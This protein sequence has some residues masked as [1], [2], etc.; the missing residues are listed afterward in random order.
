MIFAIKLLDNDSFAVFYDLFGI[1]LVLTCLIVSIGYKIRILYKNRFVENKKNFFIYICIHFFHFQIDLSKFIVLKFL[2]SI[3]I[4]MRKRFIPVILFIISFTFPQFSK[5]IPAYPFP[6]KVIQPDGTEI[7]IKL[8][9][10]E[11]FHYQT[12]LDGYLITR[13]KD[14]FFKY[15]K[16]SKKKKIEPSKYRVNNIEKRTKEEIN[17]VKQLPK[18]I[19]FSEQNHLHRL[20]RA[21][22]VAV[23]A[24]SQSRAYPLTGSPKSLVI[25]VNFSDNS[26][27]INSPKEAFTKL[28]NQNG[29]SENGST[30]SARDY[31]YDTSTGKFNPEFDVVGPYTLPQTI[32]YYGENDNDD[33]DKN[34]QQMIIDACRLA[35]NDGVDFSQYDTDK[36]GYVDN[37]F[38]YY[39][40]YNEAEGA[41]ANTI[42]PHRWTLANYNTK[43]DGVVVFDYACSSELRSSR[44]SNMCG[45]GTFCHEFGHVLGLP[46]YYP[47]DGG[48][49]FTLSY[50]NIMDAGAYL[51][52]GKTPPTYSAFDRFFLNWLAPTELKSSE[53]FTLQPLTS[54]NNAYLIS[55]DGNHNLKGNAP[56]PTE[57]FMLENRQNSG[58]DT[59]LPGHG[60]LVTHI[61]YNQSDWENN[62][63]N[64]VAGKLDYE[65]I[66]AD[67]IGSESTLSGD[68][69]PGKENVTT[70]SLVLRD[71][72]KLIKSL[73]NITENNNNVNF[74]FVGEGKYPIITWFSNF[75]TFETVQG[76]PS[77]FQILKISGKKLKD[78]IQI[79]FTENKY[80]EMRL[81]NDFSA[82]WTKNLILAPIDS[83]VDTTQ[84][85]VRYNPT[86]PSYLDVHNEIISITSKDATPIY[87]SLQG[88]ST[89]P[90][91]VVP[92]VATEATDVT[93]SSYVAHWEPVIDAT[94][95]YFTAYYISNES[96]ETTEG[97]DNGLIPSSGW[98]ITAQA[99]S[100]STSYSGKEVPAIQF[101]NSEE[102]IQTEKYMLP[103]IK[104]SF[105]V[106]SFSGK[107]ALVVEA[108][109]ESDEWITVDNVSVNTNLNTTKTYTFDESDNYTQFRLTY[110]KESGY[111]IIDDITVGF[112]KKINYNDKDKW[113]TSTTDTVINL[114]SDCDC[115][116]KIK[117]SDKTLRNSVILYENI[118]EFSNLIYVHTLPDTG[119]QLKAYVNRE[120]KTVTI[121]VPNTNTVVR[122]YDI[123]GRLIVTEIPRYNEFTIDALKSRIPG[124]LY[125]IVAGD[126]TAKILM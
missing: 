33:M 65:I 124:Q 78:S 48:T 66:E 50:W 85:L 95:Y 80:F 10:D 12:T 97:F 112:A 21:S 45:I 30:G 46:D 27:T 58:W 72:T 24:D 111:L 60:L 94:G 14:G 1:H 13:D 16:L 32:G 88:K 121:T 64:N 47:T 55:K 56:N 41:P 109:K 23:A 96:S 120:D 44:G 126:R 107:G 38:V 91:Y 74:Y 35:D 63:P 34:P 11:F 53:N 67:G 77:A 90:V 116:Y 92:P 26:F 49:H 18:S 39:A 76:T 117:A 5:A 71:G 6:V 79:T 102:M 123:T 105:F 37:I 25:L 2:L 86:E 118:T 69:F 51:N 101:K 28:L 93:I 52:D 19:N 17:F 82:E 29:Y 81:G 42:W 68:P 9:G 122:I 57:F 84:I 22:S 40:G 62:T 73:N 108:K 70:C 8:N 3:L 89:R 75:S 15:G 61:N 4:F 54:S 31:F 103:A 125:I 110:Q 43:F 104:L 113:I 87:L 83:V 106:K 7:S 100:T 99:L 114:P 115:Y 98:T 119:K 20:Q 59:Y 36:D